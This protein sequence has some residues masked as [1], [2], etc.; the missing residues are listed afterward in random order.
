[1][2]CSLEDLAKFGSLH[3]RYDKETAKLLTRATFEKLHADSLKQ[4]YSL[5]WDVKHPEWAQGDLY[6]HT[7][8]NGMNFAGLYVA[9]KRDT[10]IVI[11]TNAKAKDACQEVLETLVGKTN[12]S[13]GKK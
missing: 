6:W 8:T 9:P 1:M 3:V 13:A 4:G 7:G 2:H 10:V 11:A 12:R 5:G